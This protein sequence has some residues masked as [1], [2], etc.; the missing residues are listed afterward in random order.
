MPNFCRIVFCAPKA[1]LEEACDRMQAFCA[2]RAAAAA[3][4]AAA[5]A[6]AGPA[7]GAGAQVVSPP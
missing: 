6:E 7:G 3:A 2:R 1:K 5:P 4:A